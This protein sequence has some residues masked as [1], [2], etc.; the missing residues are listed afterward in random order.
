MW[1]RSDRYGSAPQRR[2]EVTSRPDVSWR[3]EETRE[4]AAVRRVNQGS[5]PPRR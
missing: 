5:I 4:R 1:E 2:G 3:E